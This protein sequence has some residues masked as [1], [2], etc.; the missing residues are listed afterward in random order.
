MW[1][2]IRV[3]FH[4]FLILWSPEKSA[5]QPGSWTCNWVSPWGAALTL[6]A[7]MGTGLLCLTKALAGH[8]SGGGQTGQGAWHAAGLL[9][10]RM[11]AWLHCRRQKCSNTWEESTHKYEQPKC[12]RWVS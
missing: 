2:G 4:V 12:L 9:S 11:A 5:V 10:S 7:L 1:V 6:G 3:Q 8:W